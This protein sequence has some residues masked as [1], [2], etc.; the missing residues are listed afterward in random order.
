L[1]IIHQTTVATGDYPLPT[2]LGDLTHTCDQAT[3]L[4]FTG[5]GFIAS[6][7]G[8][9]TPCTSFLTV[10]AYLNS[11]LDYIVYEPRQDCVNG[12]TGGCGKAANA[13]AL[14]VNG[15]SN[16]DF[17]L[18]STGFHTN[19]A[20]DINTDID[21]IINRT[22]DQIYITPTNNQAVTRDQLIFQ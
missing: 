3:A 17:V 20:F 10:P 9:I 21:D 7:A 11:W 22:S 18:M 19:G 16:V 12:V 14:T 6:S 2:I 15:V 8:G 1:L 5:Y 4:P 13:N